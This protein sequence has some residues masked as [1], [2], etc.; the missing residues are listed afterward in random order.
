MGAAQWKFNE[1]LYLSKYQLWMIVCKA[2]TIARYN[3]EME[4]MWIASSVACGEAEITT[5]PVTDLT[6]FS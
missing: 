3:V 6:C 5:E 2:G 4:T 1:R